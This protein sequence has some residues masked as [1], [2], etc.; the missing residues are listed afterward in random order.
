MLSCKDCLFPDVKAESL[1]P[2]RAAS[3]DSV[4]GSLEPGKSADILIRDGGLRTIAVFCGGEPMFMLTFL[5]DPVPVRGE[6]S[7]PAFPRRSRA[8]FR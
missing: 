3:V 5:N 1:K 8:V 4:A 2:A 7:T 6:F